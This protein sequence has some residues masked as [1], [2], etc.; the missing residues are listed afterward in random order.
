MSE[1]KCTCSVKPFGGNPADGI[2]MER[3]PLCPVHREAAVQGT[4]ESGE[5][6]G[7]GGGGSAPERTAQK[8]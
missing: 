7:H 2:R 3:D 6:G 5:S 8:V 4:G 1:N